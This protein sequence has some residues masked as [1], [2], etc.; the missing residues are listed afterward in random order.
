MLLWKNAILSC[1]VLVI[2]VCLHGNAGA[3]SAVRLLMA[4]ETTEAAVLPGFSEGAWRDLVQLVWDRDAERLVRRQYRVWD[5]LASHGY[6]LSWLPDDPAVDRIKNVDGSVSGSGSLVWRE[7]GAASYDANAAV[8]RFTGILI[9]GAAGGTGRYL[10]RSGASY[11]GSWK[12][13]L[14]HGYGRL[15][16]PNGDEY[17]GV[18]HAGKRHGNGVYIDSTGIVYEGGFAAGLRDGIGRI[19]IGE[20]P[21]FRAIW[22]AGNEVEG[23]RVVPAGAA[24]AALLLAQYE[25]AENIVAG[26]VVDRRQIIDP[27]A[28]IHVLGYASQASGEG[29]KVMPD[30][31]RLLDVWRGK[32]PIQISPDERNSASADLSF[33]GPA[34]YYK[35][36]PFIL[37]LGNLSGETVR[38]AGG[39]I[40]VSRSVSD[41]EPAVQVD[42]PT[43]GLCGGSGFTTS[44]DIQNFGWSDMAEVKIN[45]AIATENEVFFDLPLKQFENIAEVQHVDYAQFFEKFGIDQAVPLECDVEEAG[46]CQEAIRQNPSLKPFADA[47]TVDYGSLVVPFRGE[48]AYDW[49]AADGVTHA[50]T[51]RFELD[52]EIG[53]I[54]SMAECGEG[55]MEEG[56]FRK[57]FML[58]ADG[59]N[60]RVPIQ[61][62]DDVP[63]GVTARWRLQIDSDMT[64]VHDFRIVLQLADGRDVSTRPV[65]LTYF[66]PRP[67]P[68]DVTVSD[69]D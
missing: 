12:Q 24:Q 18:F 21:P 13:G 64:A 28:E 9:S 25:N 38:V 43:P 62:A 48:V 4:E 53:Y 67:Q 17:A 68:K 40:E 59:E 26:L 37:D 7:K 33:L 22:R 34:E 47:V 42:G 51:S 66:K 5:P 11:R 60:Y 65:N 19:R 50:K 23:S 30:N 56:R 61:L 8:A 46:A 10:H 1:S 63:P 45:G 6:D 31:A 58:K 16:L 14:M 69:Q 52:F 20:G 35:P 3:G 44:F 15:Q 36:V 57:P 54:P 29:L 2:T 55:G 41:R 39:Y 49:A 27:V 32:V